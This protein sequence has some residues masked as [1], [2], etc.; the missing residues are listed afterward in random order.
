MENKSLRVII[1]MVIIMLMSAVI[2]GFSTVPTS[3]E[4]KVVYGVDIVTEEKC[5]SVDEIMIKINGAKGSTQWHSVGSAGIGKICSAS[6]I[7]KCVGEIQSVT[8]KNLGADAWRP[9]GFYISA[10]SCKDRFC[11]GK[12]SRT[13]S[14][15][16]SKWVNYYS[17]VT[18][19]KTV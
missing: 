2:V 6:I 18:F 17:E 3:A 16:G 13:L 9:Q 19:D 14:I 11:D 1:S 7:D 4:S 15:N 12:S 10:S 5:Y 8:V